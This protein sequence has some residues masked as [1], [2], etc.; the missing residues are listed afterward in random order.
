MNS[1]DNVSSPDPVASSA[2]RMSKSRASADTQSMISSTSSLPYRASNASVSSLFASTTTPTGSRSGSPSGLGRS[3]M[4][5]S[6]FGGTPGERQ[7]LARAEQPGDPRNLILQAFVPHIAV[8]TSADTHELVKD[9]GIG[10]GLWELLRPF[11]E[12]IHGKV[13]V[14]D[15]I[16][17]GKTWEDFSV[18]FVQLGDGLDPP[19]VPTR[20]SEEGRGLNGEKQETK[21]AAQRS[22]T[23]GNVSQIES[24]V[25]RHLSYAEDFPNMSGEDYLTYKDARLRDIDTTSPFYTLYLRR[26]L[27][28]IPLTP[29]ETFAHPVACVIAI[30]SRNTTPIDALRTLYQESTVGTKRMPLW[31]NSEYLRYYV[32]VHD[33]ERDDITKSMALFDQMK[34]HFGLHCHLLRLRSSNC[35]STDDDSFRL[36]RCEWVSASEELA[37]IQTREVQED[38]E[39]SYPCIYETDMTAIRTFI[40]EMVTQSVIPSMERCV[41]TWNDQVASRRRGIG[42]RFISLSKKWTGFGSGTRGSSGSGNSGSSSNYDSLQG[43]YRPDAPEAIMRKLADYAFMLRDWKLAQSTYDLLRSDFNNDK[44]WRYHAAANEMAVIST[45][46]LSQAISSKVRSETIDQMLET[47]SYS[48]ITRCGA[49]YGALRCLA[50]GMELLRLR[51]GS[52]TEDAARWGSRLLEYKVVG[53]IGDALVKERIAVCYASK[54]GTGSGSWGGRTRK[55]ALWSILAADAWL[56]LGKPQQSKQRLDEVVSKYSSLPNKD[57]L[58]QFIMANSFLQSLQKEVQLALY[59]ESAIEASGDMADLIET[60][61]EEETAFKSRP[62]RRSLMGAATPALASLGSAPLN[63]TLEDEK[64]EA[65]P[66]VQFE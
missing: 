19:D 2:L 47:A 62:H 32:L 9:K 7:Q 43:F 65:T 20:K 13:T 17:A 21:S 6:V 26:L 3:R 15:S 38:F 30:S 1:P 5:G 18:R 10:G 22:R 55:S 66:A 37:D 61:I 31:V 60:S 11:G 27:S 57:S 4:S 52:A 48:Y 46:M 49:S 33:E 40:R 59:P 44:A 53:V 36:P 63:G 54:K 24:L 8:H 51:N 29:H 12:R 45:L 34:K 35:V 42:G 41:S 14:R 56:M 50:L 25:D 64:D 39:D 23:G 58:S 16:G 28:G